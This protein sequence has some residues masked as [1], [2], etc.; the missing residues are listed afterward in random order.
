MADRPI[1]GTNPLDALA[2]RAD[3]A[4]GPMRWVRLLADGIGPRRPT[5]ENE[6][7]AAEA[8]RAEL[9]RGG[10]DSELEAFDGYSTFAAPYGVICALALAPALLSRR[11]R[12]LRST[13]A[14]A[15][16]AGLATEGSLNRTPLSRALSRRPSQNLVATVE[17]KN[18]PRRTVCVVC[19]LDS[20]R[21]GLL[22]DPRFTPYLTRWLQL[23]SAAGVVQGAEALI[24]GSRAG[25]GMLGLSRL[26][27]AAGGALM[28]ERELRGEDTPGANDN[29][30]GVAVVAELAL[31]VRR[32]PLDS[33]RLVVLM[34]GC[35]E[36]GTLGV[37][38]F[39]DSRDTAGWLFLNFDNIGGDV[40]LNYLPREGV[41]RTWEADPGLLAIAADIAARRPELRVREASGPIGLTYDAT[42]VLARGGRALTFVAADDRGAI[43]NYH[44]PTDTT[45]NVDPRALDRTL[46]VGRQMLAAIDGG[47][48]GAESDSGYAPLADDAGV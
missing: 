45:E 4:S 14:L 34:T 26:I 41:G 43:P 36:S 10:L 13:L 32:E 16:L 38:A 35:E 15:A 18:A 27:L 28:A 37:Q 21:S 46:S 40:P 24:G 3:A 9:E 33:T 29:A 47:G 22:F 17:P 2:E 6:R 12:L 44:W 20:S 30:S 31:Q 19:H 48:A 11:R 1:E 42:P 5:S 25:R 23:Q 39:L 7:R 8:V